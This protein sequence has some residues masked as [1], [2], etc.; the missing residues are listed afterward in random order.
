M[1]HRIQQS[2]IARRRRRRAGIGRPATEPLCRRGSGGPAVVFCAVA[3]VAATN[4]GA[5]D[6]HPHDEIL[7]TVEIAALDA[8]TAAGFDNVE[9]RVRPLDRR[10]RPQ[11]CGEPLSL[12]RPP[13]TRALGPVSYGVR[14]AAPVP[15]TLYLRADV[16]ATIEVPVLRESLPRE[17]ILSAADLEVREQ[18][19]TSRAADLITDRGQLIGMALRRPLAAGSAVYRGSVV[20]PRIV[21]RGQTVTLI[22]GGDGFEVRMQGKAM[23]SGAEGDRLWVSN[24]RSGRRLEGI[25]LADGSVRVP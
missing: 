20:R 2:V 5:Q 4:A 8:A 14:C 12:L 10:L 1:T 11:R 16:S 24:V 6:V 15:W 7:A 13:N 21:E 22:A 17:T 23:G 25:I 19:I 9:V 18:V 3:A